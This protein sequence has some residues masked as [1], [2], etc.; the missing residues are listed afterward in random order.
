MSVLILKFKD[1]NGGEKA[2]EVDRDRFTIG[3]HSECD[4]VYVDGRLSREHARFERQGSRFNVTDLGSSNGTT[5]N[6]EDILESRA[7]R[8]GDVVNFGGGLEI[9]VK[10]KAADASQSPVANAT[11]SPE[12]APDVQFATAPSGI[13]PAVAPLAATVP[14]GDGIP[15]AFF[16]IA[17]VLGIFVLALVIGAVF[18]F[19][20]SGKQVAANEDDSGYTSDDDKPDNSDNDND[21]PRP[22]KTGTTGASTPP[23]GGPANS[24]APGGTDLPPGGTG[25]NAKVEQNGAVFARQIAQND[26]KA[27]LTGDQAARVGAKVKQLGRSS[28]LADNISSA[29]K[30][31]AAIKTLAAQKKLKPQFLAVAAITKLGSSRGDVLQAAAS[32]ADVYEKL[33]IHIGSEN[34]DDALLMVAAYDQ[35]AAGE[36]MKMRNMLQDLAT[37]SNEGARTVRSIWFLEKAGKITSA[38]YE[39]AITFLAIGTIAQ[40]PKEFGVNA[41]ALKL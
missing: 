19:G 22:A 38:E 8:D 14:G 33:G 1:E 2:V 39:R 21:S 9:E 31:A 4:L 15:T 13:T 6:G 30:N 34:F 12:P 29:R 3:R 28:I 17:P 27:F 40:N 16:I 36:T 41:E 5:L 24:S 26:P 37:R 11:A 32:V 18:L 10:F 7:V 23:N 25:E 20:G 35:G